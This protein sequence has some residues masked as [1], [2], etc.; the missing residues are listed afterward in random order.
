MPGGDPMMGPSYTLRV[1]TLGKKVFRLDHK[2]LP[3]EPRISPD[4]FSALS[5]S[6]QLD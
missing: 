4:N 1:Q 5:I 3:F 2:K 6:K